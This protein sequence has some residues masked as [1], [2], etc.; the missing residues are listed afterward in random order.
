MK[1]APSIVNWT[2]PCVVEAIISVTAFIV[3]TDC[4]A[5]A[6]PPPAWPL[7][8]QVVLSY[9]IGITNDKKYYYR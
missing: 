9:G 7:G 2:T 3:L 8:T 4:N 6:V 5:V 1:F